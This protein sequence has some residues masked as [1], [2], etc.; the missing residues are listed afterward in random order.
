M[1]LLLL[2][3]STLLVLAACGGQD[4]ATAMGQRP[5]APIA[6]PELTGGTLRVLVPPG[7]AAL[8]RGGDPLQLEREYV[9]EFAAEIGAE[10]EFVTADGIGSLV[11]D[12][13][14]GRGDLIAANFTHTDSRA[15]RVAFTD[16]VGEIHELLIA[17]SGISLPG[18][19]DQ[20]SGQTLHIQRGTSYVETAVALKEDVPGLR[21]LELP[22]ELDAEAILDRLAAGEVDFTIMDSNLFGRLRTDRSDVVGAIDLT[23][24]PR[25][26][27]WAVAPERP[28]LL[29][30][31]NAFIDRYQIDVAGLERSLDDWDGIVARRVFR[32]GTRNNAACCF[33]DRGELRGFEYAMARDF[34]AAH[35]LAL[36]VVIA[37]D[38]EELVRSLREGRVDCIGA[39]LTDNPYRNFDRLAPTRFYHVTDEVLV[40]RSGEPPP[41]NLAALTGRAIHIRAQS[42]YAYHL[43]QMVEQ[44]VDLNLVAVPEDEETQVILAKV[45]DGTYDLTVCDRAIAELE[46]SWQPELAI[47]STVI[48]D[49]EQVWYVRSANTGLRRHL[50]AFWDQAYRGQSYNLARKAAFAGRGRTGGEPELTAGGAISAYD[51]TI[52]DAAR[53]YGFDWPFIAAVIHQESRFKPRARSRPGAKGLMQLMPRTAREMGCSDPYDP[54]QNIEAGTRYLAWTRERFPELARDERLAFTMAAYNA[55]IGHVRDAQRLARQQGWD[56][57]RWFGHVER[58]IELLSQRRYAAKARHGY[59]RGRETTTYVREIWSAY[60]TYCALLDHAPSVSLG[61]AER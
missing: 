56:P 47:L 30:A 11:D 45:A 61:S 27:A 13:L 55:G 48:A 22:P 52:K 9:Q 42:S 1:R 6:K 10:C 60:S 35:Q 18:S 29:A 57:D 24:T 38:Q 8:P 21:V 34:A 39:M 20:L 23:L 12:L 43:Q 51:G 26:V 33:V 19:L 3:G 50:D 2:L 16:P 32:F 44:G 41:E 53:R 7:G 54:V 4:Q 49:Q 40:G 37:E 5:D 17:R 15:E 31:A 36:Q 14:A 25:P 58:A 59:V 46:R 28:D